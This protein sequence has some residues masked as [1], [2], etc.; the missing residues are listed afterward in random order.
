MPHEAVLGQMSLV[1]GSVGRMRAVDDFMSFLG[2]SVL[3][4]CPVTGDWAE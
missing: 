3:T 1:L 2:P 4:Y